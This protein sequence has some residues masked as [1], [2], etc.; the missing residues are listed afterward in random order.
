MYKT[1]P[2]IRENVRNEY[3]FSYFFKTEDVQLICAQNLDVVEDPQ[4]ILQDA[5]DEIDRRF[6]N[7][8]LIG[9]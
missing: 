8:D 7:E 1:R 2:K 3:V 6:T 9:Q 4:Q 5:M